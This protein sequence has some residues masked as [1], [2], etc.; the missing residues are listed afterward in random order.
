MSPTAHTSLLVVCFHSQACVYLYLWLLGVG[1]QEEELAAQFGVRVTVREVCLGVVSSTLASF[2]VHVWVWFAIQTCTSKSDVPLILYTSPRRSERQ[3]RRNQLPWPPESNQK[4]PS[5][6]TMRA[7]T[8]G[9]D[10][11]FDQVEGL[12]KQIV[13]RNEEIEAEE[14]RQ[15]MARRLRSQRLMARQIAAEEARRLQARRRLL[16]FGTEPEPEPEAVV[17]LNLNLNLNLNMELE[18]D[19]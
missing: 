8:R 2:C 1:A 14:A 7:L 13:I 10:A 9:A 12:V 16:A 11:H 4:L 18:G 17:H 6:L 19:A 15:L 5:M 3:A